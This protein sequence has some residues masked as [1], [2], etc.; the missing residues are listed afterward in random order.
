[1]KILVVCQYYSPEPFR[2]PDICEAL[3]ARGHSVTV[4]TGTP[5][6]PEGK[7]YPGYENGAR[8]DEVIGG[9]RVHRCPLI[10]RKSGT[11]FR[12][13]NYY[14]FVWSSRRYLRRMKEDFDV[15]F[16]NQLSP[17]MMAEGALAWAKRKNRRCVLYCLDLWPES[18]LAGGIGTDS[19]IYKLFSRISRRIYRGADEILVSSRGFAD[20]LR[21]KFQIDEGRIRYLPQYAEDLFGELPQPP[22]GKQTVDFL[23]AGNVG[24]G[25]SVETIVEAARL[26]KN[27]PDIR[28]H[29]VGGGVSL[30]KCRTLAEGLPNIT[31][32]GRQPLE[33]MPDYYAVA[34]VFL[35]SLVKDPVLSASLP[36]KVQ[37]YLAAGR[38]IVG[39]IDGET[40]RVVADGQ[41][42][43]CA[44]AEDPQALAQA[45]RQVAAQPE[46][47]RQYGDNARRYYR[48]HFEK[49]KFITDLASVLQENARQGA[50][51]M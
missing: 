30:E 14:S 48:A 11:V 43:I 16:V 9:V 41:C 38:P 17:V 8:A 5:N 15:V 7:I 25:Q 6:Y 35:V 2:L 50:A 40:A 32:Y 28:I 12:F 42:G 22:A 13:L 47:R 1:M 36:G 39:S 21:E 3:S 20:Y 34:D 45:I 37:S 4:V 33:R 10:P 24:S 18:L 26:L 46:L 27:E 51:G 29:I 19:P 44:P 49:E 31:F 23:F